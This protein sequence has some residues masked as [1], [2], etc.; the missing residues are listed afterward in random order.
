M[1]EESASL[2]DA[3]KCAP[4]TFTRLVHKRFRSPHDIPH[5]SVSTL[6]EHWSNART[7]SLLAGHTNAGDL[8]PDDLFADLA[9]GVR[10]AQEV[11]ADRRCVVA[12]LLR[13]GMVDSWSQVATAMGTNETEA[14]D[15]FHGRVAVQV[16]L[17]RRTGTIGFTEAEAAEL[18]T[19]SETVV[20]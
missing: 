4:I 1:D 3:L 16:D 10:I 12:D 11:T 5:Q 9:Y 13:F 8:D 15:G 6:V 7:Q 19:L 2:R 20:W 17:C 14:R 18:Y